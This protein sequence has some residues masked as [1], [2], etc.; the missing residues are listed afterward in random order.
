MIRAPLQEIWLRP[1]LLP[2]RS[3][4][5]LIKKQALEEETTLLLTSHDTDDMEKVCE[6]VIIINKGKIIFD[7]SISTLKDS[8][9]RKKYIE[10]TTDTGEK[11]RTEV[12]T[13]K[14][15]VNKAID[16]LVN[17]YHVIDMTVENPPMEEIIKEIYRRE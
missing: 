14:T 3:I 13:K 5:F 17:K 12:N 11:I 2:R 16:E 1:Q 6:R 8:F 15:P 9:L 7:D 4:R 10:I